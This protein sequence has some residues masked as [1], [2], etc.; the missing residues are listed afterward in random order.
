MWS[1]KEWLPCYFYLKKIKKLPSWVG[2]F[3]FN[4]LHAPLPFLV[5]KIDTCY[6]KN[7]KLPFFV[8]I[9]LESRGPHTVQCLHRIW[10]QGE[11]ERCGKFGRYIQP[12][13]HPLT[14]SIT[15]M[16]W[17]FLHLVDRLQYNLSWGGSVVV[18]LVVILIRVR[19]K[20]KFPLISTSISWT[21]FFASPLLLQPTNGLG[22]RG[23]FGGLM[24]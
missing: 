14:Q 7:T 13:M 5:T 24:L 12:V 3:W 15:M 21:E 20:V 19:S 23:T 9:Q 1:C 22:I 18:L 11:K 2:N 6:R 10:I 4:L 8:P 16:N 17:H